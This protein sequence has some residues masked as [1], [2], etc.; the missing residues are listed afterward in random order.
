MA[1]HLSRIEC[2][3]DPLGVQDQ[4]PNASLFMV[5]AQPFENWRAPFIEY[6]THERLLLALATP[7][8][9]NLVRQLRKPFVLDNEKLKRVSPP[10]KYMSV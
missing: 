8:K 2:G 4:F 6:L 7:Q 3:E 9:Q 1:D 10:T 5:Q